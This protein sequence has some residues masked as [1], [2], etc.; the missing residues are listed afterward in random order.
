[1][2]WRERVEMRQSFK[3]QYWPKRAEGISRAASEILGD[4]MEV[5]CLNGGN[6][7]KWKWHTGWNMIEFRCGWFDSHHYSSVMIKMPLSFLTRI[8]CQNEDSVSRIG[9]WC[10]LFLCCF[11][12]FLKEKISL[13]ILPSHFSFENLLDFIFRWIT[14]CKVNQ[15]NFSHMKDYSFPRC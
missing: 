6:W 15:T 2:G 4:S 12:V 13:K 9:F 11:K 10:C 7:L 1:M 5:S 14:L 3:S 8:F